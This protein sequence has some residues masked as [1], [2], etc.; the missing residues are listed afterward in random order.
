MS[1][2]S[3]VILYIIALIQGF[4]LNWKL[5]ILANLAWLAS[6]LWASVC[7][8]PVMLGLRC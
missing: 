8:S 3:S 6:E 5:D 4:L 1:Y 2:T 7:L